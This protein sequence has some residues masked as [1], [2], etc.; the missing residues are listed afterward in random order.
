MSRHEANHP[1]ALPGTR[2]D[3]ELFVDETEDGKLREVVITPVGKL[4]KKSS[5]AEG[6]SPP[7]TIAETKTAP[8]EQQERGGADNERPGERS[9]TTLF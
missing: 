1:D 2:F 7:D 6:S 3:E 8:Q 9:T 4:K 5:V